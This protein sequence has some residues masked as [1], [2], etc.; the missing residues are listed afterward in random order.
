MLLLP[1]C[2]TT[3]AEAAAPDVY[4]EQKKMSQRFN[5]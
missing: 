1:L 4:R 5:F 3:D 2:T